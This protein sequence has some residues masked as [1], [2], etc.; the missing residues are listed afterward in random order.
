MLGEPEDADF[1]W[2]ATSLRHRGAAV[3]VILPDELVL[4]SRWSYRVGTSASTSSLELADGRVM[5]PAA[6]DLVVNRW[7]DLPVPPR[8]ST[9]VDAAFIGEEWRAAV[10]AW[11]RSL[12]CPVLNPPSA[13]SLTGAELPTAAWRALAAAHG[14]PSRPWRSDASGTA[15]APG[16]VPDAV[17]VLC[18]AGRCL[19]PEDVLTDPVRRGLVSLARYVGMPLLGAAFVLEDGEP[20]LVGTD[21]FPA[22]VP[23]GEPLLDAV[24][25]LAR[26]EAGPR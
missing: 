23:G 20:V 8:Q 17:S 24:V 11:L 3:E 1:L 22:L 21:P 18:I 13:A 10:A 7:R 6:W 4:G 15:A 14:V 16:L 12:R 19:D 26:T 25:E 2:L 5:D 9:E